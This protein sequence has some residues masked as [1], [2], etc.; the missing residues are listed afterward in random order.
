V[1]SSPWPKPQPVRNL[2]T[3]LAP[4]A[5]HL[6]HEEAELFRAITREFQVDDIGSLSLL[7]LAMEA[8]QRA[9]HCRMRI[10]ADG[11]V[12]IDRFGQAKPHGLLGAERDARSDFLRAM[13]AL[14]LE[15]TAKAMT[16]RSAW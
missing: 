6:E 8:H 16:R 5:S 2:I 3:R 11:E 13:R 7:T 1:S 4:P 15:P 9:R 10:D 12:V 14:R